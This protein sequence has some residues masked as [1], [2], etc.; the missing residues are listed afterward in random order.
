M[1]AVVAASL[2]EGA[3]KTTVLLGLARAAGK[4]RYVKPLGDHLVYRM[5]RQ[6][7]QDAALMN[8]ALGLGAEPESLTIGFEPSRIRYTHPGGVDEALDAM[9]MANGD[10]PLF[11]EAGRDL[12]A[13]ASADL[14]A[15]SLVQKAGATLLLVLDEDDDRVLDAA[16][17]VARV[18][19]GK[20]AR[21][22][23]VVNK[24]RDTA[25]FRATIA[26][27]IA[28]MGLALWGVIPHE[29]ALQE[30]C[31][32]TIADRLFAKVLAGEGALTHRVR[33]ILVGA[34]S[35]DA[36]LR[37]PVMKRE[38]RLL[39]TSGERDDM[40][41]AALRTDCVG[42]IATNNT[43]PAPPV[44]ARFVE[45]DIPLL[46]ARGDTFAVATQ[47]HEIRPLLTENDDEKIEI[48]A[49]LVA[50]NIDAK[51]ILDQFS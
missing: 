47:V 26:P 34:M 29:P 38:D 20:A 49:S 23:L 9:L 30:L 46:L 48:A 11:I 32:A 27:Q 5:K 39:I 21:I 28:K 22:G 16:A 7:D 24:V 15:V 36:V 41:L 45:A 40:L 33:N 14:D 35:A 43:P 19:A 8:H 51:A 6:W 1:T 25:D 44:I 17:F 4:S 31:V 12:A 10:A 3:G 13:G 50:A 37:S 42:V 2:R 18:C